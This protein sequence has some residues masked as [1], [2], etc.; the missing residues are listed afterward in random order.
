[1]S[2]EFE[3]GMFVREP[4]WH[5]LG[6]VVDSAP[7]AE[8]A[9]KL[10]GLD[11][12]VFK[13]E[14]YLDN[15]DVVPDAYAMV[16]DRD[17]SVLGVVGNRYKALQNSEA[18]TFFDPIIQDR[19]AE[20]E[21]A[22]SLM[23]G[24]RVWILAKLKGE[25]EVGKGDAVSKY[26][27]LANSHDGTSNVVAKV[28]PIRV[29]CWNTLSAAL[30]MKGAPKDEIKIRHTKSVNDKVKEAA[31][32]LTT[33]NKAYDSLYKVWKKMTEVEMPATAIVDY[34]Q[35]VFPDPENS[36]NPYK[37][38][39]I[40]T[41]LHQLYADSS[42]GGT[43]DT[44]MGTLWGAF[45]AVTAYVDHVR[46]NRKDSTEEKHLENA[47]FGNRKKTRD[48]AFNVALDYMKKQGVSLDV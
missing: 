46:T 14:M 44:S 43:L 28:S 11:W 35:T 10:A 1:M 42:V 18:F 30:Y 12:H 22:G 40:R 19:L 5:T 38:Q 37:T 17:S 25:I 41:E 31:K 15:R 24:K 36:D 9:I 45:N 33:V 16:R 2:H 34:F 4:A 7:S 48:E 39:K 32:L 29:V 21:T 8:E 23:G 26:V 20:F 3:S 13:Q 27:L 6:T 47:W